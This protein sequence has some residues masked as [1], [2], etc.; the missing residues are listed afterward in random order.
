M[1]K[2]TTVFKRISLSLDQRT[3]DRC[4]ELAQAKGQSVSSLV[5]YV[6][7]QVYDDETTLK[8]G[9]GAARLTVT[10]RPSS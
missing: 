1:R 3:I 9:E 10:S 4:R 5:R 8:L 2:G 7:A 6:I